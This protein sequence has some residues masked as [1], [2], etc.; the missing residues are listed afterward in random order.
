MLVHRDSSFRIKVRSLKIGDIRFLLCL[1][2]KRQVKYLLNVFFLN[3]YVIFIYIYL[4]RSGTLLCTFQWICE[5][6]KV[7]IWN[8]PI[9]WYFFVYIEINLSNKIRMLDKGNIFQLVLLCNFK[10]RS[11]CMKMI[12]AL[13]IPNVIPQPFLIW[14]KLKLCLAP[15]IKRWWYSG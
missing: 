11:H 12:I 1:K 8:L 15:N 5:F 4:I 13:I 2:D 14:S 9:A 7:V 10:M 6:Y 3:D